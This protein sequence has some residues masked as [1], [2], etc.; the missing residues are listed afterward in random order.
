[1]DRSLRQYAGTETGKIQ[2][3]DNQIRRKKNEIVFAY[4]WSDSFFSRQP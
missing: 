3:I 1:M 2:F 4:W